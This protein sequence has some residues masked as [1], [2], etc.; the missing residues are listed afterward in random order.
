MQ[1]EKEY[2]QKKAPGVQLMLG[3]W[4][5]G[6]Q[7]PLILQ[8]LS[9]GLPKDIIFSCL[10]PDL[11]KTAQPAFLADIAKQRPVIA[12]PWL[13]GD[14]QLW[15]YQP[16]VQLMRDHVKL[17]ATQQLDGVIAIHWR[18]KETIFNLKGFAAFARNG[19]DNTGL[20]E[21]YN[22][23]LNEG[24]GPLAAKELAPLFAEMD[25]LAYRRGSLS[26][27]YYAYTPQWGR[28]DPQDKKRLQKMTERIESILKREKHPAFT[29]QLS[30]FRNTFLFELLLDE[31]GRCM[32]PAWLLHNK[33]LQTGTADAAALQA[34]REWFD[35]APVKELF[36]TFTS[37]IQSR[38]ELGELSAIN[39][40]LWSG[41]LL[42]QSFLQ[43]TK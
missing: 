20:S 37:K 21:L 23:F 33:W 17:A 36:T 18:T 43:Q 30:W 42:L 9:R 7:L 29:Q 1:L 10:N 8:G 35:R 41:Y 38:G 15:H 22:K 11:G 12:V 4:G 16:R 6:N 5:G 24:C 2:L 27:E 3:G 19:N 25:T 26:P 14:H 28:L 34:A 13:E 31:T 39:Q 32:E 40:K